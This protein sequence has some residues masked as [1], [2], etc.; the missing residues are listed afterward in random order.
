MKPTQT[1]E[2]SARAA[3]AVG[4]RRPARDLGFSLVEMTTSVGVLVVVLAAAWLLLT[5]SNA[6]LNHIDFGGQASEANRAALASFER[7]LG[8]SVLPHDDQSS[9]ISA[10]PRRCAMLADDN[11]DKVPELVVWSADDDTHKLLR[12][13][14]RATENTQTLSSEADFATGVTTTST[15]L[16]GL[17][18]DDQMA[19]APLF[20]YATDA[21]TGFTTVEKVG[22]ITVH[23]RDGLPDPTQNVVDR[24]ASFRV[25][26]LVINGY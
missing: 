16:A 8:H 13:V 19:G 5:T 2:T 1:I 6:N 15:V 25:I 23:L 10:S 22:L 24:T 20:T 7:D 17:A 26:A 4:P 21:T 11:N 18:S 9:I 12:T 3:S 14:T